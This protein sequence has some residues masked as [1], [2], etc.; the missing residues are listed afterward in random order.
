MRHSPV[1]DV[2]PS[3][4]FTKSAVHNISLRNETD[5]SAQLEQGAIVLGQIAAWEYVLG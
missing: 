3:K 4:R 2:Q 1:V 5:V